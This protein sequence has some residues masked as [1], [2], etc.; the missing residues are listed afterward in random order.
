M[1]WAI[2]DR[3]TMKMSLH[4]GVV[5]V[6]F[7]GAIRFCLAPP[8]STFLWMFINFVNA[9]CNLFIFWVV[10]KILIFFPCRR[11]AEDTVGPAEAAAAPPPRR[12][13]F[14]LGGDGAGKEISNFT[15]NPKTKKS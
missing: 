8:K 3:T 7:D 11:R 13:R 15:K 6:E 1:F 10:E 12:Q 14:R 5:R 4:R 2:F 9:F